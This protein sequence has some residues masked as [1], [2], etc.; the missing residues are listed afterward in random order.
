MRRTVLAVGT[1]VVLTAGCQSSDHASIRQSSGAICQQKA[2][3]R[4]AQLLL[5]VNARPAA[6]IRRLA[7]AADHLDRLPTE[8]RRLPDNSPVLVCG[9]ATPVPPSQPPGA[10]PPPSGVMNPGHMQTF[11]VDVHGR[12]FVDQVDVF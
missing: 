8:I 10:P 11:F 1:A 4:H 12:V 2:T 3:E 6:E 9:W 5:S 7:A